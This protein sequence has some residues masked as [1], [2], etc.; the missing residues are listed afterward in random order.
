MFDDEIIEALSARLVVYE[1]ENLY[2]FLS[3]LRWYK[4]KNNPKQLVEVLYSTPLSC[5]VN[6]EKVKGGIF[7]ANN[8]LN[9]HK[10]TLTEIDS[11][12]KAFITLIKQ[13]QIK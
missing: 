6:I 5:I 4:H 12:E 11:T 8:A 7:S 3:Y 2:V 10:D 1:P 13:S 9:V